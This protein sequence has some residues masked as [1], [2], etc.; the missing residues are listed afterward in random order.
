MKSEKSSVEAVTVESDHEQWKKKKVEMQ[1]GRRQLML[2]VIRKNQL[3]GNWRKVG[4]DYGVQ[5]DV[6]FPLLKVAT[7]PIV[8][9]IE[10][11]LLR[12]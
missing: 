3:N 6:F 8:P 1:R 2:N 5:L 7:Q 12:C 4:V 10:I 9:G 11:L